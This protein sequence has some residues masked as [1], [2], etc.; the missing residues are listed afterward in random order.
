MLAERRIAKD[1]A[2]M[3]YGKAIHVLSPLVVALGPS[4]REAV[5]RYL[6]DEYAGFDASIERLI[7]ATPTEE[8][9]DVALR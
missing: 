4:K 5:W 7:V 1:I 2:A 3:S 8:V 6:A 9:S